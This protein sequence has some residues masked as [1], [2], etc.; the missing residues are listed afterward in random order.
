[1]KRRV[2]FAA[3]ESLIGLASAQ[4]IQPDMYNPPVTPRDA[5]GTGM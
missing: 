1:M 5:G 4:L 2:K 3:L